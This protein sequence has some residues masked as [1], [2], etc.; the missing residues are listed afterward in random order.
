MNKILVF[1]ILALMI[2]SL[3]ESAPAKKAENKMKFTD[4]KAQ[5]LEFIGYYKSIKLTPAQ[6]KLKNDTLAPLPAP[7]CSEFSM[8]TCCCPCNLSKSIWGL[9][10]YLIAKKNYN[11]AQ[12]KTA[13]L[14]WLAFTHKGQRAGDACSTGRCAN[15]FSNDGCGGMRESNIVF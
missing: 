5:T 3:A 12:L 6:E 4:V 11:S 9:S 7:C 2:G 8:A 15:S 10:N 1:F 14:E 13:V